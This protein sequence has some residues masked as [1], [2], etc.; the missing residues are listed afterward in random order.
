MKKIFLCAIAFCLALPVIANEG[1][2]L[3]M[4]LNRNYADMQKYGLQLTAEE[5][6]SVNNSSLKDA[7][8]SFSGFCT[9][10]VISKNGLVLTNHHCGYGAIQSH[11][12]VENNILENG[13]FAKS[14]AEEKE[15]PDLF[16][17]F[18]VRMEDVSDKINATMSDTMSEAERD[19]QMRVIG[20][21]L[22]DEATKGTDYDANVKSFYHGN[23]FYLFVYNTYR[24]I[25]L[26]GN[27]PESVGKF[28]GRYR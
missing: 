27:P 26:V 21:K 13:F 24:D 6:Y 23:E 9:G 1:M 3:P 5:L 17:R 28:G 11:S 2:W 10:E 22:A 8:V 4:L 12:T 14:Y 15:N 20:K 7:I 25:R 18:L 16:V 19:A